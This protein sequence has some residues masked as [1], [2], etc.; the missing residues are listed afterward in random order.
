MQAKCQAS[1]AHSK[2]K[3]VIRT[4]HSIRFG[5]NVSPACEAKKPSLK[6]Y[7]AGLSSFLIPG[8]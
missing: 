2:G 5:N 8:T 7:S 4:D 6:G 3:W 1:R